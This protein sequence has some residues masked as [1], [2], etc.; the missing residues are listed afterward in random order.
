MRPVKPPGVID[1]GH[2]G[3]RG[4]RAHAGDRPQALDSRVGARDR[5]DHPVR[6]RELLIDRP[7]DRQQGRHL[8]EQAARQR[9]VMF[10]QTT[11]AVVGFY[12]TNKSGGVNVGGAGASEAPG[13]PR[14]SMSTLR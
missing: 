1:R 2:E 12:E 4:H 14:E 3:R 9:L 5:L 6:V 7:H 10:T 11:Y 13:W 8:G